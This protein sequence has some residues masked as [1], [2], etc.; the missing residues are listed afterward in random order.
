PP[1]HAFVRVER[2]DD[3][4][5]LKALANDPRIHALARGPDAVAL[6]WEVCQIPDFR[7]RL[8]GAHVTLLGDIYLQLAAGGGRLS[9]EWLARQVAPLDDVTGDIHHLMDRLAAIRIWTYVSNRA[10]WLAH[11]DAWQARTRR[12]E[13][14]L[15][16]ALHARLVERF[17]E[18]AARRTRRRFV[19]SGEAEA[20]RPKPKS[21][22]PF[23]A[24]SLLAPERT[25]AEDGE[26]L[27]EE[28]FV[29]SVVAAPH[30]A[31]EVDGAGRVSFDGEPLARLVRGQ[32]RR[33]PLVALTD[34]E[35]WT[36]GARRRLERRM[37]AFARDLVTEAMGGFPGESL[38]GEGRS[39]ATRGLAFRLADGL[40]VVRR[41]EAEAQWAQLADEER[42]RFRALGVKQGRRYLYVAGATTLRA[43]ERRCLLSSLFDG[44]ASPPGA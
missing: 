34:P 26:P 27:T 22:S 18:R 39:P 43:L 19:R 28:Q 35:T 38:S 11:A 21:D 32:D 12:M 16:D 5:A 9:E 13:D 3:F 40:G 4:D 7:K 14:A 44:S 37:L 20:G 23:A 42:T 24:L 15:G 25:A 31:F 33:S 17:V 30:D 2:A 36:G 41:S 6:L 10:R 8:F 29:E 1:H